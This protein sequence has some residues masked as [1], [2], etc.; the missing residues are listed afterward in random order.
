MTNAELD[1]AIMSC[2]AVEMSSEDIRRSLGGSPFHDFR[3]RNSRARKIWDRVSEHMDLLRL[4]L[5]VDTINDPEIVYEGVV[6][7]LAMS[8][9][10]S[11]WDGHW[12]WKIL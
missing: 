9:M 4:K 5:R 6:P 11:S 12:V 8:Y 1:S 2:V 10:G 7:V 3:A